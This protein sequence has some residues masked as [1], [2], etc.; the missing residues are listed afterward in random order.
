MHSNNFAHDAQTLLIEMEAGA[1]PTFATGRQA[2]PMH[3]ARF[4]H[5][6]RSIA[7]ELAI[8]DALTESAIQCL[9][10]ELASV[11]YKARIDYRGDRMASWVKHMRDY[12]AASFR[13]QVTLEG[14]AR[15]FEVHPCHLAK[16]MRRQFG[17]TLGE[18]VRRTRLRYVA[19]QLARCDISLAQLAVDAGFSDQSH[20]TRA[21]RIENGITPAAFRRRIRV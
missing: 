18:C 21:F 4:A 11:P 9:I 15:R 2:E 6:T 13:N 12:L 16:T 5:L 3:E 17:C 10:W 20:M 1:W 8:G 19:D 14:M 7:Y